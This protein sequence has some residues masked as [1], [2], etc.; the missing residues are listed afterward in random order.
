ML[1]PFERLTVT[2][3]GPA[4][5][6]R[7]TLPVDGSPAETNVGEIVNVEI[8]AGKIVRLACFVVEPNVAL[9][10]TVVCEFTP[11]LLMVNVVDVVLGWT[12]TLAG[13]VVAGLPP[14]DSVMVAAVAPGGPERVT[15][16][17]EL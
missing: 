17:V 9:I 15:L 7:T 6:E 4:G 8:I 16:P 1:S 10:V 12:C 2:P 3:P 14:S 13:N 11:A 5:P